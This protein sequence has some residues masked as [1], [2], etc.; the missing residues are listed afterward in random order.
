MF[1]V[2]HSL[3]EETKSIQKV[4]PVKMGIEP[5]LGGGYRTQEVG[6]W[7]VLIAFILV[8][9]GISQ[10]VFVEINYGGKIRKPGDLSEKLW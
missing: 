5:D 1:V 6:I 9:N 7:K 2:R 4:S 10:L 8:T 3:Q